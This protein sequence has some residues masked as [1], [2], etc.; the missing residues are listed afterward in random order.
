MAGTARTRYEIVVRTR[1]SPAAL[2]RLRI[3]M[4]L[5][6]VPRRTLHRLRVPADRDLTDVVRSFTE[7]GVQILEVRRCPEPPSAPPRTVD[8]T[9]APAGG[10][11]I[12]AFG[13]AAGPPGGTAAIDPRAPVSAS[14]AARVLPLA[15]RPR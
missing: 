10:E 6:A 12:V 11:L 14:E 3:A 2:A 5:T 7:R 15:R 13:A 9:Q 8:D 4:T 1:V